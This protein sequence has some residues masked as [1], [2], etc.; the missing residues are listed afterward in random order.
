[1]TLFEVPLGSRLGP[2]TRRPWAVKLDRTT[3]AVI[4][5]V[6]AN[7]EILCLVELRLGALTQRSLELLSAAGVDVSPVPTLDSTLPDV[8]LRQ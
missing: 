1:M 4:K 2:W 6:F 7:S 8:I 3:N 5:Q